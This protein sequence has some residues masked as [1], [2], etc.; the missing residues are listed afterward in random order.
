MKTHIKFQIGA[1]DTCAHCGNDKGEQEQ[2]LLDK[3]KTVL[4]LCNE[5]RVKGVKPI[6]YRPYGKQK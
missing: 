4:P 3:Y 2:A 1:K 5:C 6:V